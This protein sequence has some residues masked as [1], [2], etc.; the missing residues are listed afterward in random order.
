MHR[1]LISPANFSTLTT[2]TVTHIWGTV[3]GAEKYHIYVGK[4]GIPSGTKIIDS[5]LSV[6]SLSL[7]GLA[8]GLYS[9]E[10]Y[11]KNADSTS[12]MSTNYRFEIMANGIAVNETSHYIPTGMGHN[13]VLEVYM[14]NGSRVIK[15]AYGPTTTRTQF[16]NTVYKSLAKGYY[17]YRLHDVGT[18]SEIVGKLIK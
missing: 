1:F 14:V 11:A 13:G 9:W 2:N 6:D 5:I 4:V 10:V 16:L 8:Q 15:L 3:S 17:T 7:T 18:N 12:R